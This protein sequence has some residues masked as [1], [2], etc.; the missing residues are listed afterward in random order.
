M[1]VS[2]RMLCKC[3][4]AGISFVFVACPSTLTNCIALQVVFSNV[5]PYILCENNENYFKSASAKYTFRAVIYYKSHPPWHLYSSQGSLNEFVEGLLTSKKAWGDWMSRSACPVRMQVWIIAV[6][7]G[8]MYFRVL[9]HCITCKSPAKTEIS[10][11]ICSVRT[12]FVRHSV[13]RQGSKASSGGQKSLWSDCADR[14]ILFSILQKLP[15]KFR[16]AYGNPS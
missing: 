6:W 10:L 2:V 3:S 7:R 5:E 11:R 9:L 14:A 13:G 12:V 8:M 15:R 4:R 16:V 1:K